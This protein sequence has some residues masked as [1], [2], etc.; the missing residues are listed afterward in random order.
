MKTPLLLLILLSVACNMKN[1]KKQI[2]KSSYE[3]V[4]FYFYEWTG[5]NMFIDVNNV[6]HSITFDKDASDKKALTSLLS[7]KWN[8]LYPNAK[9]R[10]KVY[11]HYK[12]P[13]SSFIL[14]HWWLKS[15]FIL[16]AYCKECEESLEPSPLIQKEKLTSED[17]GIDLNYNPEIYNVEL[18]SQQR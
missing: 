7:L 15:P 18:N 14:I 12:K 13:D 11:G 16:H 17:F 10:I 6:Q 5:D 8:V 2:E 9:G 1:E 3:R 4:D